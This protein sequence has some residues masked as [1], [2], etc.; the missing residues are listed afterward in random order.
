MINDDNKIEIIELYLKG[1]L[2]GEMLQS[3][4]KRLQEDEAFRKQVALEKEVLEGLDALGM[5]ELQKDL[6]EIHEEE[7]SAGSEYAALRNRFAEIHEEVSSSEDSTKAK[8]LPMKKAYWQ[9][10]AAVALLVTSGILVFIFLQPPDE[11][12]LAY[13]QVLEV[14]PEGNLAR[15]GA[16]DSLQVEI[17]PPTDTYDNHY[18]LRDKL[19][20]YGNF[21]HKDLQ[22]FYSPTTEQYFLEVDG[23]RYTLEKADEIRRLE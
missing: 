19:T 20:L 22:F 11:P 15:G 9:I 12:V 10:A 6:A 1:E 7:K 21:S 3:F 23:Q 13:V 5:D 4:E 16:K 14:D 18:Q 2:T 8:M 17:Y